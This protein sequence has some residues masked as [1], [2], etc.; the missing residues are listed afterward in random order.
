LFIIGDKA[1][2]V[3]AL[4]INFFRIF[5]NAFVIKNTVGKWSGM[6][7]RFGLGW[8]EYWEWSDRFKA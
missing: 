6:N 1:N 5:R 7:L 2:S 3:Q 8:R 4:E